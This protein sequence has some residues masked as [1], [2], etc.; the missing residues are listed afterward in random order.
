MRTTRATYLLFLLPL[1]TAGC[2][3]APGAHDAGPA[4][5]D[6]SSSC[7][8]D[9][10]PE[11]VCLER[12]AA[13]VLEDGCGVFVAGVLGRGDD[14]NPGTREKPV[15]TVQRGVE[16]ART[17]RGRVF[18]CTDGFFGPMT[19]PSGVDL[20]GGYSCLSWKREPDNRSL[21]QLSSVADVVLTVEPAGAGDTGA[22]DGVSK[23]SDMGMRAWGPIAVLVKSGTVVEI[24]RGWVHASYGYRG[25]GGQEWSGINRA[26]DGAHGMYGGDACSAETVAGGPAIVNP[27]DDAGLP[28]VGGKG[29]D[30]LP[31]GAEAGDDGEPTPDPNP[32]RYGR[33]GGGDDPD[34]GCHPGRDGVDGA[35][36]TVGAAGEGIGRISEAGWKG[37]KADDGSRGMPGQGGGGGGGRRG[38]LSVC[39]VASK[40]GA[41][42]GSGASGGCGGRGGQGGGNGH[43]SIAIVALHARLTVRDTVIQPLDGGEGGD[44]GPPENGGRGGR[45][46]PGGA[47]GDGT[48]GCDGGSGGDGGPGG[49]GG[50]G[51]GGDSIGVAYL[52]EDQL[53][54]E[55]VTFELGPPGK[56]GI[57]WDRN[58]NMITGEDGV[59]VETLRFPE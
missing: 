36:G 23:I 28:S 16:L 13:N 42:G 3:T 47:L 45:G 6:G 49:Y 40:G 20:I 7:Q 15:R 56:G 48:Y 27:C 2:G 34:V 25:R 52:D 19:L 54:L 29:G 14:A 44:G 57:S 39:G 51:R 35:Q 30:G 9:A 38:G 59:A 21:V 31:S 22:A 53:T 33:G 41:G 32:Q 46:A 12:L 8:D 37:D 4:P 18:A 58:G 24:T 17:G 10:P 26:P 5:C 50:P 11:S 55:G 1:V 43:P